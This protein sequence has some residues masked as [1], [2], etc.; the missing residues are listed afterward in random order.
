MGVYEA[1]SVHRFVPGLHGV[2]GFS[3]WKFMGRSR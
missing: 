1:Y 2:I 3:T